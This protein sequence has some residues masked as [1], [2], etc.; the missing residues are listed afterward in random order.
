MAQ[1]W[2]ERKTTLKDQMKGSLRRKQPHR[3]RQRGSG[4][5]QSGE[6]LGYRWSVP[7]WPAVD[8]RGRRRG[9]RR[10]CG[11][12]LLLL[13]FVLQSSQSTGEPYR[14]LPNVQSEYAKEDDASQTT[15][16]NPA[17]MVEK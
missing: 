2:F 16:G 13:T 4:R 8:R 7:G 11:N 3:S 5:G 14:C 9:R 6:G 10:G 15:T 1:E 12:P 17:K